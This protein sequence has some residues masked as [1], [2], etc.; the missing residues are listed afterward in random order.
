M[1]TSDLKSLQETYQMVLEK[2]SSKKLDAVGKEDE[3]I[4]N[5]G[6]VDKT[7]DYLAARRKK[8][9]EFAKKKAAKKKV[10]KKK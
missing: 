8:I 6:E 10:V 3:D 4:N 5:D 9:S 2:K 7:D 1:H